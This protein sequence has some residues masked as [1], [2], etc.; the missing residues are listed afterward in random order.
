MSEKEEYHLLITYDVKVKGR[1]YKK[2][3]KPY[4]VVRGEE[5][6]LTL[7]VKNIGDKEFPGGEFEEFRIDWMG[8]GG[9]GAVVTRYSEPDLP[10]IPRLQPE[11]GIELEE[12]S[13]TP[14]VEGPGWIKFEVI[15]NDG[16]NV[17]LYR[18]EEE[19]EDEWIGFI[20]V[21]N[22]ELLEVTISI[23]KFFNVFKKE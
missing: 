6:E 2:Y 21:V 18:D 17:K 4:E 22:R 19:G 13:V 11:E 23:S 10:K 16:Q 7:Y 20:Y 3:L 1:K 12:I 9:M 14:P 5:F 8:L 15:S